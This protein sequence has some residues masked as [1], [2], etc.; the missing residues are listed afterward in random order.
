[1]TERVQLGD[2]ISLQR[3]TSY[4]GAL[5]GS[6][7]IPLLGLGTI[8]RNGGFRRENVRQYGGDSPEKITARA[9]DIY[10]S[11]KDVT[12]AADLLGAAARVPDDIPFGRLTQDT[13]R[14][15]VKSDAVDKGYL[16]AALL[17]PD[18]RQY[19]RVRGTGTTNLDLSREDFY[20]FS[21]R[22]PSLMEQQAIA[23]V[24]GALDDKIAA[25]EQVSTLTERLS[26]A[27]VPTKGELVTVRSL[28]EHVRKQIEPSLMA[29]LVDHFSLP[30]FDERKLPQRTDSSTIKSAKF[31]LE[32]PAVLMSKLNPR[33][34]RVW[35]VLPSRGVAAV[36]STEFVV[37][38]PR[39]IS[40]GLLATLLSQPH[41]GETLEGMAA[42]T[43]GSHQR[44]KPAEIL[45]LMV[46]DPALMTPRLKDH[47]SRLQAIA[48][49]AR[50]ESALM[51]GKLRVLDAE[52]TV[53]EVL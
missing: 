5:V 53:G 25:N 30:A 15:D 11:L 12:H 40:T 23:E 9:G 16:Y 6:P 13:V 52:K 36:A 10:V 50:E 18:Y 48:R 38:E 44:V 24:L 42:G 2:L 39:E 14:V 8:N 21:L 46:P 26:V 31:V 47:I 22:L 19:C 49:K 29:A 32:S 45:S 51:S 1:M 17:A 27:L 43:S 37:L 34:P 41:L 20:A 33:F 28:A 35:D 4:K 7:G 3:G